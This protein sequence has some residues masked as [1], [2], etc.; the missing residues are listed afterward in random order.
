MKRLAVLALLSALPILASAQ[1]D[2]TA[3]IAHRGFW[4]SEA[5]GMS[6]NSIAS[7]GAAQENG[8]YGSE[9]DIHLTADGVVIVNHDGK[10][11]GKKI[12]KHAFA[13]FDQDLLPNGEK[14]PT[15]DEYLTRAEGSEKTKLIVE[16]KK[17]GSAEKE[18]EL[19]AKALEMIKAH[20]LYSPDRVAF[21][22]FSKHV[23]LRIAELC[24][25]FTNQYLSG[26]ISPKK[27]KALGIN[28][29]DYSKGCLKRHPRWIRQA[30]ELGLSTNVW[31]VNKLSEAEYFIAKGIG[32]ITTN[33]PL[34]V[35]ELLGDSELKNE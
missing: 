10:I 9:C 32:A 31:T 16:F 23:C 34:M 26:G 19:V 14:R 28:G 11:E 35:R 25:E 22:S 8:F 12:A 15:F 21:I 20:G 2:Q 33:E 7:L 3:V 1:E 24:P 18:D 5:G 13:D 29:L 6:Q 4:K 17:Q 30:R 27:L